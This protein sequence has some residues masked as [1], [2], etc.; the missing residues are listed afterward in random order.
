MILG[1]FLTISVRKASIFIST[2]NMNRHTYLLL[3]LICYP[4]LNCLGQNAPSFTLYGTVIDN[5]TKEPLMGASV[6]L[7]TFS[8]GANTRLDG[9]FIIKKI[10][11]NRV[12]ITVSYIGYQTVEVLH[13]FSTNTTDNKVIALFQED[14]DM[15]EV[16]I[17]AQAKGQVGAFLAQK[18][19]I[20]I[21]NILSAEQ[22]QAFPDLNAAEA[23]QRIPGI[24]LQRDQGQGRFVQLRGTPPELTNFN[25]NG[26]QIPSPEGGVRYVGL[27]II[28]ADQIETIEVTKVLTPDMDADGIGGNVNII[29][30]TAEGETPDIRATFAAGYNHL[31]GT[32]NYQLQFTYGQRYD[33]FGFN[34]NASYFENNQGAD[35]LEYDY[36]KGPFFGS[37]N[38]GV[39]NFLIQYREFQLRHYDLTRTRIGVSPSWD[40]RF[41]K[42]S[43]IYVRG[44]Y[45]RFTDDETRRRLIY[46]LED[47]LS[48]IYYLYGGVER[49][50]RQRTEIQDLATLNIGGEH[51]VNGIAF[52]YMFQYAYAQERIP[53]LA[54]VRF[55]SPGQAI[56]IDF[57]LSDPL[58]PVAGFPRPSD[59]VNA[60]N[61]IGYEMD[62]LIFEESLVTD[63][64]L[65][66][67]LN[68]Q[69][70]YQ[71]AEDHKGF[72]K[73]GGK[74]RT[75]DKE[76]DIK[77]QTFGAY[78]TT[79]NIYPGEGPE[80]NLTTVDN[81]FYEGDLLA[82]G[83]EISAIPNME[84]TREFYEA[85]PQFFIFDRSATR[86]QSF[87]EDYR[88]REEIYAAYGMFRHDWRR[89]TLLGGLRYERT[90]IDYEGTIVRTNRGRFE[91]S[92][93]LTDRRTHEFFLPQLQLR[94]AINNKTNVKA[95]VT[96][97]YARPNFE[98][99]LPYR[100]QDLDEVRFG[101]PDLAFPKSLNIDLL[102]EH[103]IRGGI[104]SGGLFYK[105]IDDF[106]FY[107]TRFAHE[108]DPRD[109]G[110]V[111]ITKA[112]NGIDAT[113]YRAEVQ[114]Q[115][116]FTFLRGF[117]KN[118]G[119]YTNYTFTESEAFVNQRF[120]AN[121]S[122]A[123]VI[124]GDD[125][126]SLF[127]SDSEIETIS[128]PGQAKHA[129]NIALTYTGSKLFGRLVA[130]YNDAF[131][132]R[133]GADEDLDEYYDEAWRLDLT[134]NYRITPNITAFTD[135]LNLTNA[136][137]RFFLGTED[138][139]KQQEFYSWT[140]RLG[141][142]LNF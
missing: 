86:I 123:V 65:A 98:D 57:D 110:L 116:N 9:T 141:I 33:K 29:T 111:E 133:L 75:K 25:V 88:A 51:V 109:Y 43:F 97:T 54:E 79:S 35:N 18:N 126:L 115:F 67:R 100:E 11:Q 60:F 27:D 15:E 24:T 32:P 80:L 68:I 125:D 37:Q 112:I 38:L 138:R 128:L 95:A 36:V 120:P 30:K 41:N 59:S 55:D 99:V 105:N 40:Y 17:E 28:A 118:F 91:S 82:Q 34:I 78:F 81:G 130:N 23:L 42:N 16:I 71:F 139:I 76:R 45:N 89:L 135:F 96:Q 47:A 131:L 132:F 39:D 74:I 44:F 70:P 140:G 2:T 114:A 104:F 142:K 6:K 127:S 119:L 49:D 31:R 10:P 8:L 136:P 12:K 52:D 124:F 83:Y 5:Q 72:F 103:Y 1:L 69:I 3:L 53:D 94:Y 20:N 90:D 50:T 101:N 93:P 77:N 21:K 22:I 58:Y 134:L 63:E 113:V 122:D 92:E 129:A 4:L 13:D 48:E 121:Y 61:F 102:G 7:D 19:A 117:W 73:F 107:F 137:L 66:G 26:E 85:N 46:D 56:T 108:G 62:E 106:I 84:L 87:A 64:N 14:V